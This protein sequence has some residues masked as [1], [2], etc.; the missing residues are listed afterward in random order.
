MTN[1]DNFVIEELQLPDSLQPNFTAEGP[2]NSLRE[3]RRLNVLIGPNNSGKSRLLRALFQC[4]LNLMASMN[5]QTSNEIRADVRKIVAQ[6]QA[7]SPTIP[8]HENLLEEIKQ[9][10]SDV[11]FSFAPLQGFGAQNGIRQ[12]DTSTLQQIPAKIQRD[13]QLRLACDLREQFYSIRSLIEN[14]VSKT[15]TFSQKNQGRRNPQHPNQT[16]AKPH[17]SDAKFVYI[18][19]LRGMRI[20]FNTADA[21]YTYFDRTI[22]DYF[23]NELKSNTGQTLERLRATMS[24]KS[25]VTGLDTYE[26]V[27]DLLLGSLSD[28]RFIR[29]FEKFLS[30]SFFAGKPVALIPRKGSDTLHIKVGDEFERPVE[31]MGDGIQQIVILTLPIFLHRD[32]PLFLFIEEPD[33]FLHP[34]FQQILIDLIIQHDNEDL[35]VFVTTH[36]SQF[37]DVTLDEGRTSI[38]KCEKKLDG[39]EKNEHGEV[40]AK[41]QIKNIAHGDNSILRHVG[42]RP[43]SVMFANCTIWV[44]GITDRLYLQ[45]YLELEFG[46]SGLH[47]VENLHYSFVEYGGGNITHWSFLDEEGIDVDRLCS[48][49]F[50]VADRDKD[51]GGRHQ[52]L[53]ENLGNRFYCLEAKEIEN[54]LSPNVISRVIRSYEGDDDFQLKEFRQSAYKQVYLGR[55]IDNKVYPDKTISKRYGKLETCFEDKSGTVKSKVEFCRRAVSSIESIDCLGEE[56]R[57][58]AKKLCDF[59]KEQNVAR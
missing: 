17:F 57:L 48:R 52:K 44:E 5:E 22:N 6:A 59:I 49:L 8:S 4:K 3:I 43:S 24:G 42:V 10:V 54:L 18:P 55:F 47:F 40:T 15:R 23:R 13:Y 32:T 36:S 12:P 53:R 58:I 37:V 7:I 11:S 14:I 28:R 35:Y 56:A 29:D 27:S 34:G 33:L 20:P 38:F 46:Q 2:F 25:I 31:E 50:L 41:F 19:T 51:K 16:V 9:A 26:M 30:R 39:C 1:L 21:K 45:K